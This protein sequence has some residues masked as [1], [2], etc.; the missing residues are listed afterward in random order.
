M[1]LRVTLTFTLIL[2]VALVWQTDTAMGQQIVTDGLVSAYTFDDGTGKDVWGMNDCEVEGAPRPYAGVIGEALEFNGQNDAF[3]CGD[4]EDGSL[5]VGTDDYTITAWAQPYDTGVSARVM[6]KKDDAD[7]GYM[8]EHNVV[9][10]FQTYVSDGQDEVSRVIE[11]SGNQHYDDMWHHV[12]GVHDRDDVVRLYVNGVE[13]LDGNHLLD[14]D[15]ANENA[16]NASPF[17]IARRPSGEYFAGLI[18]ELYLYKKALSADEV[19]QNM[20]A[21]EGPG[22]GTAVKPGAKLAITWGRVKASR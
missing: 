8:L 7:V 5:D 15:S 11:P 3:N 14:A 10:G 9:S 22:T 19:L 16:D 2:L 13:I 6:D 17:Y 12:A 21:T 20:N 4:P 18:D 1:K